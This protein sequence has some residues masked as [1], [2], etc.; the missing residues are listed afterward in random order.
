MVLTAS[1]PYIFTT[2]CLSVVKLEE[3]VGVKRKLR[4]PTIDVSDCMVEDTK[5]VGK[6]TFKFCRFQA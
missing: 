3:N 4:A 6:I 1:C 2:F 5:D